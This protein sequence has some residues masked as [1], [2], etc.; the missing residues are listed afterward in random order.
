MSHN[1]VSHLLTFFRKGKGLFQ[2]G[3]RTFMKIKGSQ[4][5]FLSLDKMIMQQNLVFDKHSGDF[6]GF[7]GLSDQDFFFFDN[8][9]NVISYYVCGIALDLIL[10][11]GYFANKNLY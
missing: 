1:N 3:Q 5:V 6:I 10:A 8:G 4:H 11:L 2:K 7:A 9:D